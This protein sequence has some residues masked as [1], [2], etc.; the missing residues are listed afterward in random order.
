MGENAENYFTAGTVWFIMSVRSSQRK[1][2][3][4]CVRP[5][6]V[7]RTLEYAHVQAVPFMS[8]GAQELHGHSCRSRSDTRAGACYTLSAFGDPH[9]Q[10]YQT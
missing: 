6:S 10:K 7:G 5:C 1:F 9:P 2:Y 3:D 8:I 4:H